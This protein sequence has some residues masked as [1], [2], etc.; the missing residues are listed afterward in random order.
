MEFQ[1]VSKTVSRLWFYAYKKYKKGNSSRCTSTQRHIQWP[2]RYGGSDNFS[3]GI[4]GRLPKIANSNVF[5][6][7]LADRIAAKFCK[8]I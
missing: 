1:V 5:F 2:I 4:S 8:T 6:S 3:S 7:R